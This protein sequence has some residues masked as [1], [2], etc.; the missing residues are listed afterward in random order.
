MCFFLEVS[1]DLG[2]LNMKLLVSILFFSLLNIPSTD[3]LGYCLIF[4]EYFCSLK[5]MMCKIIETKSVLI[6]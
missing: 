2:L 4:K 6:Q 3:A 1:C 5:D